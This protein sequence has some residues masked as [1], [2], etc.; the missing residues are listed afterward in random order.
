MS[1]LTDYPNEYH[2]DDPN[3]DYDYNSMP[4][5]EEYFNKY[6]NLERYDKDYDKWEIKQ[7]LKSNQND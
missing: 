6:G 3:G 4:D 2:P 1:K 7:K 5:V